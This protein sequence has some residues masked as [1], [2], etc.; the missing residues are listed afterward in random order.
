[1][2]RNPSGVYILPAGNPVVPHTLIE[3]TWANPTMDDIATALTLSLP[4]DGSAPMTGRLILSTSTAVLANEAVPLVQLQT[5]FNLAAPKDSPVFTGTVTSNGLLGLWDNLE[6]YDTNAKIIG[7]WNANDSYDLYFRNTNSGSSTILGAVPGATGTGSGIKF[8]QQPDVYNASYLDIRVAG[9]KATIT[10][11]K[12]GT[13]SYKPLVLNAG[14]ADVV[15]YSEAAAT[16]GNMTAN[17]SKAAKLNYS[18]SNT[19]AGATSGTSFT[20]TSDSGST[21]LQR[22]STAGGGGFNSYTSGGTSLVGTTTAHD[23]YLMTNSAVAFSADANGNCLAVKA[24]GGLGYGAGAGGTVTQTTSKSTAV[25]L[26]NPTGRIIM[27]GVNDANG[28]MTTGSVRR[29]VINN[30]LVN[31]N[32]QFLVQL[33]NTAGDALNYIVWASVANSGAEL[34]VQNRSAGT[35]AEAIALKF[36]LIKG[37]IT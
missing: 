34:F 27:Y 4:R 5:E 1:M 25:T 3:A 9:T 16:L 7:F 14:G 24:T 21:L 20:F 10:S 33:D 31:V 15:T 18:L 8:F 2:P 29:F 11:G 30:N 6:F 19:N 17:V 22:D 32:D 37:S 26:N 23:V 12:T 28:Q 13:G 35:L 36:K